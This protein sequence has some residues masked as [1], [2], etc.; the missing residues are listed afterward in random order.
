MYK[1][2]VIKWKRKTYGCLPKLRTKATWHN[3]HQ[4]DKAD[5]YH[6]V[7]RKSFDDQLPNSFDN[8]DKTIVCGSS[9]VSRL[10]Q[11]KHQQ[12]QKGNQ[13]SIN[14]ASWG[15]WRVWNWSIKT[16]I[17]WTSH[18]LQKSVWTNLV[19]K[20][21]IISSRKKTS[22]TLNLLIK[23]CET[24]IPAQNG[25]GKSKRLEL[26]S[27]TYCYPYVLDLTFQE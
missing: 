16:Q 11:W 22:L 7:V 23:Y 20:A 12:Y 8:I 1:L 14:R 24:F 6:T 3:D 17:F 15:T 19:V 13:G 18:P 26:L 5:Y 27:T 2:T 4:C 10:S 21:F 25:R 9:W